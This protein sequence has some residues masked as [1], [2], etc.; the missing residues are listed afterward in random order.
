[1]VG[2]HLFNWP[3]RRVGVDHRTVLGLRLAPHSRGTVLAAPP[4]PETPAA[5]HRG[6]RGHPKL[7]CEWRNIHRHR[8]RAGC[9]LPVADADSERSDVG[10]GVVPASQRAPKSACRGKPGRRIHGQ[11]AIGRA[12]RH[13]DLLAYCR[14][15][16]ERSPAAQLT[17]TVT[18]SGLP[19]GLATKFGAEFVPSPSPGRRKPAHRRR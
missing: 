14:E 13:G 6:R 10:S 7:R 2:D 5:A 18:G 1:M 15:I 8:A 9:A 17:T 11:C 19:T 12:G 4:H 3:R 16:G